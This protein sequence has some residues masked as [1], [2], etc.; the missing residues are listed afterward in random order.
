MSDLS[1]EQ[2]VKIGGGWRGD[3]KSVGSIRLGGYGGGV[4]DR[5]GPDVV[6]LPLAASGLLLSLKH[7]GGHHLFLLP[8]VFCFL[9][10]CWHCKSSAGRGAWGHGCCTLFCGAGLMSGGRVCT[11]I[12]EDRDGWENPVH[13]LRQGFTQCTVG[14][15][16]GIDTVGRWVGCAGGNACGESKKNEKHELFHGVCWWLEVGVDQF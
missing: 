12:G 3:D 7:G 8:L 9:Q 10:P 13:Q 1:G 16:V 5:C 15:W 14:M 11:G 2:G 4:P 6:L